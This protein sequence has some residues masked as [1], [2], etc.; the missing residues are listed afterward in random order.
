MEF[1]CSL[2]LVFSGILC[3]G[4]GWSV[5]CEENWCRQ[6][7]H[8]FSSSRDAADVRSEKRNMGYRILYINALLYF[9]DRRALVNK[10]AFSTCVPTNPNVPYTVAVLRRASGN[11]RFWN[12][13]LI[14]GSDFTILLP[15]TDQ[16]LINQEDCHKAQCYRYANRSLISMLTT[17]R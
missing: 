3:S 8:V 11:M 5:L 6:C 16:T 4:S 10:L 14:R 12:S 17:H 1:T 13:A 7:P 9:W 2:P 15:K